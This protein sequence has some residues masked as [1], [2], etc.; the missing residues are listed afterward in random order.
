MKIVVIIFV[1]FLMTSVIQNGWY[2]VQD[3]EEHAAGSEVDQQP[4]PEEVC[5][6]SHISEI[7]VVKPSLPGPKEYSRHLDAQYV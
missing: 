2:L 7:Q 3:D 1:I 4:H 5:N 6:N